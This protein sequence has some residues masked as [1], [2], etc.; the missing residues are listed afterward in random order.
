MNEIADNLAAVLQRMQSACAR[1]GRSPGTVRL[2][3]VSKTFPPQAIAA[4]AAAGQR[5]FGENYVQEALGKI[6]ALA[7]AGLE[8]HFIGPLQSN[9][10]RDVAARFA[11]V[12]AVDRL[13]IAER[14]AAQRPPQLAPLNVCVQVNVSGEAS[15]SGCAPQQAAELCAAVARLPALRLRGLMAIPAAVADAADA[16]PAFRRMCTLFGQIRDSGAVPAE[17]FDT[18]SMGMSADFE[19]AIEEGAT[20]V[21]VG[22]AIFGRRGSGMGTRES[23]KNGAG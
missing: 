22:S 8:W 16:R 19:V 7:D 23:S 5:A 11:W 13:K 20:L 4:A 2:I 1:A 17:Q 9:K 21:R 12:H 3:A 6:A 14:L 15:K 10:T 18:L